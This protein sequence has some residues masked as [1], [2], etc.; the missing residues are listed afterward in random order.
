MGTQRVSQR[1]VL[2]GAVTGIAMAASV[3]PLASYSVLAPFIV[4]SFDIS[5]TS[6]GLLSTAFLAVGAALSVVAGILVDRYGARRLLMWLYAVSATSVAV[7]VLPGTFLGLMVGAVLGGAANALGNPT[8]NR[9]I[10]GALPEGSRGLAIG[11]KQS[12]IQFSFF[13][14]GG[15]PLVAA[16]WG[17]RSAL[18]LAFVLPSVGIVA[19]L[20]SL[21]SES[22]PVARAPHREIPS[23]TLPPGVWWIIAFSLVL[24]LASGSVKA[25]VSLFAVEGLD[26][27][28]VTAGLAASVL[29]GLGV[30]SGIAWTSGA[31]RF[32]HPSAPLAIISV[33]GALAGVLLL[34]APE[35][36]IGAFWLGVVF[37]G[38]SFA[39]WSGV[40][41]LAV[42]SEVPLSDAGRTSGIVL[43]WFFVGHTISPVVF[44]FSVDVTGGYGLGWT[45]VTALAVVG[46]A[47]C[48]AWRRTLG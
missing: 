42:I 24:G 2:V 41:M 39:A 12:G 32:S 22:D 4:D 37:A 5:R 33:M 7:M 48:L 36:G 25:Y 47:V 26:M 27:S 34:L 20:L 23:K 30:A 43:T 45:T 35:I 18:A 6:L 13:A 3:I 40:S 16:A 8:T 17:W 1:P 11:I 15:L 31:E 44:G 46:L 10:A 9:L 28:P 14:F 29:A 19:S 21:D 38:M